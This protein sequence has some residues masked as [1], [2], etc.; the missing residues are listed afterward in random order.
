MGPVLFYKSTYTKV[1]VKQSFGILVN[2]LVQLIMSKNK[3]CIEFI[4]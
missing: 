4:R 2:S 1:K 3:D